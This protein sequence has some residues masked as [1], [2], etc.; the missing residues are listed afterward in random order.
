MTAKEILKKHLEGNQW[1]RPLLEQPIIKAMEEYAS[2]K[3]DERKIAS[4]AWIYCRNKQPNVGDCYNVLWDL[5]DGDVPVVTTMEWD[6]IKKIWIDVIN[7][8]KPDETKNVIA[9]QPLPEP[10]SLKSQSEQVIN[11]DI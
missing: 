1:W 2:Q 3:V 10:P 6:A 4:D 8:I 9:W 11:K 7:E 5:E